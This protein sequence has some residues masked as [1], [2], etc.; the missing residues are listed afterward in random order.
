MFDYDSSKPFNIR[1]ISTQQRGG[2]QVQDITFDSAILDKPT[3]AY[4]VRPSERQE[5]LAAVLYVH[6]YETPSPTSNRTQFLDE[7]VE[8]AGQGVVS[9][10]IETMWSEQ[11]WFGERRYADDYPHSVRQ[12]IELRRA[13]DVLL[14]QPGVDPTRVAYVGHDFGAMY[15]ALLANAEARARSYVLIAGTGDFTHWF[16]FGS[17]DGKLEGAARDAFVAQMQ[18]LAP[19]QHITSAKGRFFFQ[20]GETDRFVPRE[21]A[22][23]FYMAAP[24]P[25]RIATYESEHDMEHAIIRYDRLAWLTDELGLNNRH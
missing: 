6:W 9:L 2:A 12:V 1:V 14:A 5:N 25:K 4:L 15:G 17:A 16:L 18:P 10:L 3:A 23:E 22:I 21:R 24:T 19:T 20:F 11:A 13:L 8:I 7:A